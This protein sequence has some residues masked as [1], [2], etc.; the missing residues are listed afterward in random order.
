ME[1]NKS[2]VSFMEA[3]RIYKGDS[4]ISQCAWLTLVPLITLAVYK[5][6]FVFMGML[7]N[8]IEKKSES[9]LNFVIVALSCGVVVI[10]RL[11]LMN[12]KETP[13][14]K[15]FRTVKGGFDTYAKAQIAFWAQ[16]V[17]AVTTFLVIVLVL[18][19][20]GLLP[21]KRCVI[22]LI[23]IFIFVFLGSAIASFFK[24]INNVSVRQCIILLVFLI[25]YSPGLVV[26]TVC[27]KMSP[28]FLGAAAA[29][30]VLLTI[31]SEIVV[32]KNYKKKHWN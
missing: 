17:A 29:A 12:D 27:D 10:L 14:G 9:N 21:I 19:A 13:G 30:T 7:G 15:Y 5:F 16:T 24:M 1:K 22:S 18:N 31:I 3:F 25:L 23:S 6:A 4:F 8:G 2:T 26:E 20:I 11:V 32:L 28:I